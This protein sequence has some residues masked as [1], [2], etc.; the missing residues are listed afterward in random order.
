MYER[1]KK[2]SVVMK[3]AIDIYLT[4]ETP[5]IRVS[6]VSIIAK[7]GIKH[8]LFKKPLFKN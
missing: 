3:R 4:Y 8:R 5:L 1:C 2:T 7:K 6:L